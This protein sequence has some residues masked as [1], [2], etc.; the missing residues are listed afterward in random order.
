V[1][2]D[3]RPDAVLERRDDLAARRVVLGVGGERHQDVERQPHR[4]AFD[5]DVA[6]LKDVEE[7][8]LDL[9]GQVGQLVDGEDA[10][11]GPRQQAVVHRQLVR[12]LQPRPR[13]LDRVDVADHVR[14]GDVGRREL[15]HV[16]RVAFEPVDRRAVAGFG[17]LRPAGAADG[18]QRVVVDLAAWHHRNELVEQRHQRA[19]EARLGLPAQAQQD[20][21]VSRQQCVDQL[22]QHRFVVADD[23]GEERAAGTQ[24]LDQVVAHLFVDAAAAHLAALDGTA[25]VAQ[26]GDRRE[27]GH[28]GIL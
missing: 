10:A 14:D 8:H 11:V 19:Q 13:R 23:A 7:P 21:V 1:R 26:R 15:F 4:V 25:Q 6:F 9:A 5:L 27:I 22:G 2:A 18:I 28:I 24:L 16:A 12:Q 17:H 3:L 20:E